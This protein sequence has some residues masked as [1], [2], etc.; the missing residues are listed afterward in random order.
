MDKTFLS[1]KDVF[2]I[3]FCIFLAGSFYGASRGILPQKNSL[4]T[5]NFTAEY[6]V[7]KQNEI[8]NYIKANISTLSPHDP[9]LG[10]TFYVTQI[11]WSSE[12]SGTVFYE[13]GHIALRASF[14]ASFNLNGELEVIF[15]AI[16]LE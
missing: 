7:E 3:V 1:T 12:T 11:L 16:A 14:H 5:E 4:E 15:D 2:I 13:D 6:V 10:G 9:V 8:E